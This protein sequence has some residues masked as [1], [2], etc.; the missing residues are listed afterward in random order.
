[1]YDRKLIFVR[2]VEN[3]FNSFLAG[4]LLTVAS[5]TSK[6]KPDVLTSSFVLKVGLFSRK[7]M[8]LMILLLSFP[9]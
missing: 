5:Q 4:A 6:K 9:Q 3:K 8:Q 2:L 7:L 1:M